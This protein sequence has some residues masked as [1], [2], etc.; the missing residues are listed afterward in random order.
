M[1]Q[2][3]Q[4]NWIIALVSTLILA[5]VA[6]LMFDYYYDLNDDVL[7]KDILSGAYLGEP[8]AHN[9]QNLWLFGWAVSSL[10]KLTNSVPWYGLILLLLQ[11]G[12]VVIILNRSLA[13][14]DRIRESMTLK[15]LTVLSE[16]LLIT[17]IT[18][19][20]LVNVQYTYTVA[21]IA[22]AMIAWVIAEDTECLPKIYLKRNIP[23]FVM[24]LVGFNLRSEM[25]LLM[26]PFVA[27]AYF[28]KITFEK[29]IFKRQCIA[30]YGCTLGVI[31]GIMMISLG[32]NGMAYS[33]EGWKKFTD[34]FDART[35]LYDFQVIPDYESN[36]DFY[37]EAGISKEEQIL[38]EN[39]NF[40]LNEK[41][42]PE[43]M[44]KVARFANE[45]NPK[46]SDTLTSIKDN[47]KLYLYRITHGAGSTGSDYPYNFIGA[48][49]YILV[50]I[51]LIWAKRYNGV[52][53][54]AVL[55]IGRTLIWV[56]MMMGNRMPERITHSLYLVE[57]AILV[58]FTF[59]FVA[60]LNEGNGASARAVFQNKTVSNAKIASI[61]YILPCLFSVLM[62]LLVSPKMVSN[63][64]ANQ[65]ERTEVNDSY[66]KLYE[67]MNSNKKDYYYLDVY[68]TVSYSEKMFSNMARMSKLNSD[69]LGGWFSFSPLQFEKE[70]KFSIKSAKDA[71]LNG[72]AK[73]VAK[74]DTDLAWLEDF[75]VFLGD[76]IELKKSVTVEDE[77]EIYEIT[78]K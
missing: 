73:L 71:L 12:S 36:K 24:L 75:Y 16:I 42:T 9:N 64:G 8:D 54:L 5:A 37:E 50:L 52:I 49:F 4:T 15:L 39:Y 1:H 56:Y 13:I 3:R 32:V 44:W 25:M 68:S 66:I 35:E 41:M 38:F 21:M 26:L 43:I 47:L 51:L 60:I 46:S 27:V 77:F 11:Y 69:I 33:G 19:I 17:V 48:F 7:I 78:G 70:R 76:E 23:V 61:L 22:A 63:I 31:I 74:K 62:F 29:K 18:G 10:Y 72:S 58:M 2:S 55:F 14:I 6:S 57:I 65:N 20:H 28:I 45:T 67:Y 53:D 30:K 59:M 34:L 40:K